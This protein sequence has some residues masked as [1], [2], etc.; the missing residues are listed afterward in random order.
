LYVDKWASNQTYI[1]YVY[2]KAITIE[3]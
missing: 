3:E 2:I 1:I